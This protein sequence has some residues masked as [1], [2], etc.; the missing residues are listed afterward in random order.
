MDSPS[1]ASSTSPKHFEGVSS[2]G[3]TSPYRWI[4]LQLQ[5]DSASLQ[6]PVP[7]EDLLPASVIHPMNLLILNHH[8]A[9]A[10]SVSSVGPCGRRFRRCPT[11]RNM[12]LVNNTQRK[13]LHFI[14]GI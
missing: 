12:S 1:S 3:H 9:N 5:H 10:K 4:R 8:P 2:V 14:G 7:Q 13:V 6:I 11:Y